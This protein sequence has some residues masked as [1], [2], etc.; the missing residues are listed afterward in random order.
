MGKLEQKVWSGEGLARVWRG[1]GAESINGSKKLSHRFKLEKGTVTLIEKW[2][3]L[4]SG[5]FVNFGEGFSNDS[6]KLHQKLDSS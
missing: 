4:L 5:W 3:M 6:Q 2:M 1:S